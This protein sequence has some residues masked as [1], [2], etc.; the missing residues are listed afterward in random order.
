MNKCSVFIATSLD[1]FIARTDGSINW[2]NEANALVPAGED[3]GYVHFMSGMDALVLGRNT[4]EQVLTFGEWTYGRTPLIVLSH[5]LKF[6]PAHL[7]ATNL[8]PAAPTISASSKTPT[9][10]L[11]NLTGFNRSPINRNDLGAWAFD[12]SGLDETCQV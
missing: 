6:L 4:F 5:Q 1:G 9:A 3:C 8:S 12:D 10:S 7:P 11:K 2:L